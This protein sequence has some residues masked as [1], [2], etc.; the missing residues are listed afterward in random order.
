MTVTAQQRPH[1]IAGRPLPDRCPLRAGSFVEQGT[2]TDGRT[3]LSEHNKKGH[4]VVQWVPAHCSIPGN[5]VADQLAK[6]GASES[7]PDNTLTFREKSS[8]PASL[9][10]RLTTTVASANENMLP[11]SG[12]EPVKIASTSTCT[13][14]SDW[15]RPQTTE[16][17]IKQW[18]VSSSCAPYFRTSE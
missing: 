16:L 5:K 1:A 11:L 18:S 4:V 9:L 3:M 6:T 7:Q 12:L 10:K 15:P 13:G 17:A 2:T 14:I 8:Q